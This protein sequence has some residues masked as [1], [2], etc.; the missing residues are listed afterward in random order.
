[1]NH[2]SLLVPAFAWVLA[3]SAQETAAPSPKPAAPGK[4]QPAPPPPKLVLEAA[5]D[6]ASAIYAPGEEVTFTIQGML[7]GAPAAG[8]SVTCVLSKDGIEPRPPREVRLEGGKATLTA[9]LDEP[10]FLQLRVRGGGVTALAAA[11]FDPEKLRPSMPVPDDFDTFWQEQ[12]MALAAVPAKA[13]LTPRPVQNPGVELFDVQVDC[14]GGA[15]VSGYLARPTDAA[16]KSLPAILTVHG[17]GVRSASTGVLSWAVREGGMLALDINAH[18]IPN[19]QPDA[20]YDALAAG[21]LKDYRARGRENRD[22]VYFKG[23]FLR[24]IRALDFLTARPEWDGRTLIVYGSSQG[25]FQAFAAAGLDARVT[26]ICA[27]VPAGC[28]HTGMKAGRVCGWPKLAALDENGTPM[29]AS[30]EAARYFD[31]VNFA[32]RARCRGAAVTV[33]FID[34]TCPPSSVYAAWNAL[35][36]PKTLHADPLA[37]HTNTPAAT[38]FMQAAALAHVRAMRAR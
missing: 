27:G 14:A 34:T 18:G 1:M 26:F 30:L 6:R 13:E 7:G 10:G 22:Q 5:T 19:G 12:K 25:G 37:G 9:T 33:G 21:G 32:A 16:P 28:D 29:P 11:A 4:Q 3:L 15:P 24:V 23:M 2:L 35:T 17:A 36:V 20:F 8:L 38:A 31:C